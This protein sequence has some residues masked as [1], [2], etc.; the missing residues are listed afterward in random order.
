MTPLGI[1]LIFTKP[2]MIL[3]VVVEVKKADKKDEKRKSKYNDLGM[4]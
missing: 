4:F 1:D 2:P 3:F